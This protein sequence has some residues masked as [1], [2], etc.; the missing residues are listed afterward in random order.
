M[1]ASDYYKKFPARGP[2]SQMAVRL[3]SVVQD[4][5]ISKME[6]ADLLTI[7]KVLDAELQEVRCVLKSLATISSKPIGGQ[8]GF[9]WH[10]PF[11]E[12]DARCQRARA[13]ME[14][15]EVR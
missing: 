15:L 3:V 10:D 13:L 11:G 14:R 7:P 1:A 9:H 5:A 2:V 6:G 4:E 8:W 12:C